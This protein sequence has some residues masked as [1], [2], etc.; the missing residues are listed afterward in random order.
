MRKLKDLRKPL[1]RFLA[2]TRRLEDRLGPILY[3]LPPNWGRNL[4]RLQE[5]AELLPKNLTHVIEFRD[6]QW[7][8]DDT[9]DLLRNY[10]LCLC[11]HDMLPRHPRRV[12]GSVVYV[13]FHGAGKKYRGKYRKSRLQHWAEWIATVA[14]DRRTFVYF[15]NDDQGYAV[16]NAKT[17]RKLIEAE[18]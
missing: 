12:T 11:V 3:Q 7:L 15:N 2:G 8:T 14:Q 9:Y 10:N 16:D 5:F 13:R 18:N 17:L 1:D 6:R 4:D